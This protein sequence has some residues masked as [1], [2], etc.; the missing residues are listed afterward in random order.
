MP[1]AVNLSGAGEQGKEPLKYRD[2]YGIL[3]LFEG[4]YGGLFPGSQLGDCLF[5]SA[6][7]RVSQRSEIKIRNGLSYSFK[8]TAIIK[9]G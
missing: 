4:S 2:F 8:K 6:R 9:R 7:A 3:C 5:E 1:F